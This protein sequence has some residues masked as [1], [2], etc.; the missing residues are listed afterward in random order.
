MIAQTWSEI[1]TVSSPTMVW[2]V[3]ANPD[4]VRS[5]VRVNAM[6]RDF[7]VSSLEGAAFESCSAQTMINISPLLSEWDCPGVD[8][9]PRR[10]TLLASLPAVQ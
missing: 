5:A 3:C 7:M 4:A 10:L 1:L 2:F 9:G 6:K 8:H